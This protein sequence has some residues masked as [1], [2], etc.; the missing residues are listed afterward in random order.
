MKRAIIAGMLAVAIALPA[1]AQTDPGSLPE[2]NPATITF[3]GSIT[4][5]TADG[6]TAGEQGQLAYGGYALGWGA[7]G[8]SLYF[9][10]H[11]WHDR[12]ARISVPAIGDTATVLEPCRD[13][14]KGI[15]TAPE[16]ST[17]MILGGTL[18]IG[19]KFLLGASTYYGNS[20]M[21]WSLWIGE[22]LTAM[23]G[24]FAVSGG[25]PQRMIGGYFGVIP[26]E[27]RAAFGGDV[28]AGRC[29]IS[30]ISTVG[31][32]P[33][34]TVLDSQTLETNKVGKWVLGYPDDH[35]T[36]GGY[37]DPGGLVGYGQSTSIGGVAMVPGTNTT[38]FFGQQGTRVCYG[39]GTS[40]PTLD[41]KPTGTGHIYCYDPTNP[42]QGT[43]GYPFM[44]VVWAY[45]TSDL[46]AVKRGQKN[47]WDV[48][49]V[50]ITKLPGTTPETSGM[51]AATY[52]P[53]SGKVAVTL[54][55]GGA[56]KVFLYQVPSGTP[57][58]GPTPTNCVPGTESMVSDDSATANC[59]AGVKTITEQWT[60]TGDIQETNGGAKCLPVQTPRFR[61]EPCSMPP[62][63]PVGFF[64]NTPVTCRLDM[65]LVVA[66]GS[67]QFQRRRVGTTTWVNHGT[68]D[69][70]SPYQRASN[71]PVGTYEAQAVWS[72][73]PMPIALGTQACRE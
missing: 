25:P 50:S 30:I 24:P 32:G 7:G 43:H 40:D 9:G 55:T 65:T 20:P 67:V 16:A 71:Q 58:P 60:R 18:Q 44:R 72:G 13:V 23:R 3:L 45:R 66:S 11:D 28:V 42:Y 15:G 36:I 34:L 53:A 73:S 14:A 29:C 57:N 51:V 35:Q 26:P 56:P 64:T 49:P 4:V 27:F 6:V 2:L 63:V 5:P 52:D 59:V 48:K 54:G 61:T 12:L 31:Y 22:S 37:G 68:L 70:S 17:G 33:N 1:M 19:G 38:L 39:T 10:C 8:Q 69:A 21:P 46:L 41:G 47:P 62:P